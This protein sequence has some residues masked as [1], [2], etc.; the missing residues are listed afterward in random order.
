VAVPAGVV[1]MAV[2]TLSVGAVTVVAGGVTVVAGAVTVRAVPGRNPMRA[3]PGV[4]V[5]P[6]LCL[7]ADR[8]L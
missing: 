3:A 8:V 5:S 2:V 1:T 6:P 4:A 7:L